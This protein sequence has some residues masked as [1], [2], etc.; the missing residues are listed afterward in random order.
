[1]GLIMSTVKGFTLSLA[2]VLIVFVVTATSAGVLAGLAGFW[3]KPIIGGVAAFCVVMSAY[4][5]APSHKLFS[6]TVW[7]IIGAIAAWFLSGDSYYPE[8]HQHAYQLTIIPLLATYLSGVFALVL[9]FVWHKKH[10]N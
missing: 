10:H 8:D 7:L 4:S 3:K 2:I 6:A 1:M 5:S 9:C